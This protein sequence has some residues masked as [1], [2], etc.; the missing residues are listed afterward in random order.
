M[1]ENLNPISFA[2]FG[3]IIC[4]GFDSIGSNNLSV[5]I[6]E[7]NITSKQIDCLIMHAHSSTAM[8]I[9]KDIAI[10]CV[11]HEPNETALR[12]FLLDKAVFIKPGIYYNVIPLYGKC[13]IKIAEAINDYYQCPVNSVTPS[14]S[15]YPKIEISKI[16]TL[17]YQEKERAFKF[18]G[19][20]HSSWEFTYV[21]K[22]Y[23]YTE[24][25]GKK[26]QL[27]QGEAMFYGPNQYHTQYTDIHS[28]VCFITIVFDMKLQNAGE[29]T[30]KTFTVDTEIKELLKKIIHEK[31]NN[32]YYSD[33]IILCYFKEMTIKLLRSL[34]IENTIHTLDSASKNYI[35]NSVVKKVLE[36]IHNNIDKKITLSD[37][38]QYVFISQS[39]LSRIFKKQMG[40]TLIEYINHLKLEKSKDLIRTGK[41]SLTQIADILGF[42]S[43]HYFSRQFKEKYGISPSGYSKAIR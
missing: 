6:Y 32:H 37:I 5:N 24:V 8:D 43:V 14:L 26:F 16:H 21:D 17:F 35:E 27:S 22:G 39:Y 3:N 13:T 23:M 4:Q 10:L 31:Q 30:N 28:S 7:K 15:I 34:K 19:E 9:V 18:N 41:Y 11:S 20:S 40:V 33:D 2:D 42:T 1:I 12:Y 38:S 36:Y 25:N 29:F